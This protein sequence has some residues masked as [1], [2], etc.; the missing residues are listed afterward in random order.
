MKGQ[1]HMMMMVQREPLLEQSENFNGIDK[2][3]VM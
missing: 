3:L 1:N 2:N